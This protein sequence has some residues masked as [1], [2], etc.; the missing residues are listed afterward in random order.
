MVY[1]Y[2]GSMPYYVIRIRFQTIH[3]VTLLSVIVERLCTVR[4]I[5]CL[6]DT[7]HRQPY[8]LSAVLNGQQAC[9]RQWHLTST[10]SKTRSTRSCSGDP[11]DLPLMSCYRGVICLQH[12]RSNREDQVSARSEIMAP[13]PCSFTV[14]PRNSGVPQ[15]VRDKEC[16]NEW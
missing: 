3:S 10:T 5:S 16:D 12:H 6:S 4:G 11:E 2:S 7:Y 8:P 14:I 9:W 15:T 1:V 13:V